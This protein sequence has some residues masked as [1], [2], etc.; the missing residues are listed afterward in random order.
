MPLYKKEDSS[1]LYV[2]IFALNKVHE[3][4]S[5]EKLQVL[6]KL[7]ENYGETFVKDMYCVMPGI[8]KDDTKYQSMF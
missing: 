8:I 7:D 4:P 6:K 1:Y 3:G 2:L 5:G